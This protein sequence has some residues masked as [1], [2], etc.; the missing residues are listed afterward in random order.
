V[1]A[2]GTACSSVSTRVCVYPSDYA[3]I[4]LTPLLA[5]PGVRPSPLHPVAPRQRARNSMS[6]HVYDYPVCACLS[7]CLAFFLRS[8]FSPPSSRQYYR[9]I[10]RYRST[11]CTL[12]IEQ[13][14]A[15]G[16]RN[17]SSRETQAKCLLGFSRCVVRVPCL[18]Y[19]LVG[20][21]GGSGGG[22]GGPKTK[23]PGCK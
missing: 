5:E 12:S 10:Y 23:G 2:C 4:Y 13:Q 8:K 21:V 14:C 22:G 18:V 17:L 3:H 11:E 7:F 16:S 20:G 19:F 6:T 1:C 15:L 9:S